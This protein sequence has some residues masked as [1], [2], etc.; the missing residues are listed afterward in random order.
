MG[1]SWE[2]HRQTCYRL[3]VEEN[4]PLDE[5]VRYMREHHDFTPSRRAFQGAF[6]RW[7]FPNKLNPAYKNE[8]LVARVKELWE[9]NLSQKEMLSLLAEEGYKVG[10]REVARIRARNGWL[11]RGRSGLTALGTLGRQRTESSEGGA[12][13]Q[14][15][16]G[17]GGVPGGVSTAGNQDQGNYWDYGA[18]G[19]GPADAQVQE[20][21]LDAMREARRE[22]RK[23]VLEAEAH[24]R[25]VTKK[26]RRHTRPYGGLPADPPGPPRFPSETTLSEAKE[27]LQ[28]DRSAYMA[29]REKFYNLCQSAGVYKKTLVG[30]E[31]WEALKD[32]L[33]RESMHLRAVMWDRADMEKKKLAI[34]IICCDV[35]KRIRTEATAV[36]VADAKVMLGLNPEEGRSVRK[37]L[38][39]ILA[40]EKFTSMLEEG[41]EYFEELKQRW[42]AESPELSR[43]IA[44]GTADP[45]YQR[46]VKAIN[47]LCRDAVRRYRSDVCRLGT[48]PS[49][50]PP[51]PEKPAAPEPTKQVTPKPSVKAAGKK[52]VHHSTTPVSPESAA[53]GPPAPSPQPRRRRGRLP[54]ERTKEQSS[55]QVPAEPAAGADRQ[56][57][58]VPLGSST[59]AAA[60]TQ[61]PLLAMQS[62]GNA[63]AQRGQ[64]SQ[65]GPPSP[66]P[67]PPQQQQQQQQ[68]QAGQQQQGTPPRASS[69]GIAAFFRL[70]PAA[71]L[72]FP[73][74]H[75]QWIAPLSEL[76]MAELRRAALQKTPG[77]LCY[78]IEGMV[79]D[80]RGGELPLLVSDE[81]ELET[82]LQHVQSE[83]HGAPTF[84]VHV[85]PGGW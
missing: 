85:V 50:L 2:Q 72:M 26:R 33:V 78:K 25:W 56:V 58:D 66:P 23:R 74:V 40:S 12:D 71:Q 52:P 17:G 60:E 10:E 14:D 77:G 47:V 1:Y 13:V 75:A 79:K 81:V 42:I 6:A 11:M 82:Y 39:N 3:Y 36:K 51:P 29:T 83:G 73:G 55:R 22:Y 61:N 57:A 49:L 46:K 63:T 20:E 43:S 35:T 32:Q 34:E 37:Q 19:L 44:A 76:T 5:V 64:T 21:T 84:H 7:G 80:G 45:D 15:G 27:I 31:R 38:Y 53:N 69:S 30:P 70:S 54:E 67:P 48:T 9:R 65:Q 8:R 62:H 4:R 28:M 59:S 24:E 18:S 41:L 68:Q 16:G